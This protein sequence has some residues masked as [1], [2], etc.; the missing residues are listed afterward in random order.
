MAA[1]ALPTMPPGGPDNGVYDKGGRFPAGAINDVHYLSPVTGADKTMIV[2]TPPSYNPSQKYAVVYGFHGAGAGADTI[3]ADWCMGS[4]TVADNLIGEGKITPLIIVAINYGDICWNCSDLYREM[5][6]GVMSYIDSHYSTYA[7]ADHR[8]LVGYSMGGGA[9]LALGTGYLDTFRHLAPFSAAPAGSFPNNGAEAKQ[10]MKTLLLSCGTADWVGLYPQ[11]EARH[12]DLVAMGVPH[13]WWPVAGGNHDAGVWRPAM[14]NFLQLADR[15][16]ISDPPC[17][18][19]AYLQVEA[20]NYDIQSGVISE[21]CGEGGLDIGSIQNGSYLVFKNIDFGSGAVTFDARVTSATSGGN[22]EVRLDSISGTLVGTCTVLGTG[23]WQTWVTRSCSVS[24]ATGKHDLYL[25]FTGSSGYL[26]NINWWKFNTSSLPS[27]PSAPSGLAATAG[28]ERTTLSWTASSTATSYNVKRSTTSGGSYTTV[29]NVA[30]TTYTDRGVIGGTPYYYVVSSLNLG[31]EGANS[32]QASATP[33]VNVPSP[34]LTRDIGAVGLSGGASFANGVFTVTGSGADI[35]DPSDAFRFVHVSATGDCTI[36]T[37]VASL[38]SHINALSKAGVMIRE[39]LAA[40]AANVFIGVTPGNGVIWQY[41]SSTGGGT[42][43][44]NT[45]GIS[46]PY[47]VKLVRSGNT[48]TGSY[49]PNGTTW[50]QLGSMTI[51]MASTT[52][53]GLA[54]TGHN[55]YT[56]CTATFDHVTAPGWAPPAATTPTGLVATAGVERVT[57]NWTASSNANS[58]NV[59][60]ST[61]SGGPYTIIANI[62]TTNYIDT[63]VTGRTTY[64]YVVSAMSNLAG[65]SDNSN[66]A[67]A[68]PTINVPSPWNTGDIGSVGLSGSANFAA[69][70][71][72]TVAGSGGDIWGSNDA[73][74]FVYFQVTGNCTVVARVAGMQNTPPPIDGWAKAGFMIRENLNA[75]SSNAFIAVTPGNGVTFQYRSSAGGGCAN[76]ASSG[77]APYWVRLVRSGDTFTGYCSANG[78]TWTQVGSTTITMAST[79]YIGLA[80]TSHNNSSLCTATFDNVTV[81]GWSSAPLTP[82]AT[83]VSGSQV[84]LTWIALTGATSYNVKR[85]TVSGGPYT[86]IATGVTA[87]NY[88]DNSAPVSTGCYY[89]IS[90][91]VNGSETAN[92]FE[93][94]LD[95]SKL[96]GTIIGTEGSWNNSGNTI[97]KVFDNDLTTFF[98]AP[99]PGNGD[100]VGLDF[101]T[102]SSVIRKINYCPRAGSV[103]RMVGGSFQGANLADFSDAVTLATVGTQPAAGAFTSVSITNTAAFRYVRYLSPNS[104]YGNVAELEFYGYPLVANT[105]PYFTMDPIISANAIELYNYTGQSLAGTAIDPDNDPLTYSKVSGPAWLVVAG[106]GT[107]SGIP[108][109][110]NVGINTFTVKVTDN[111]GLSDTAVMVITVANIYSGVAGMEDL[112]GLAAQW[113]R[114]GCTDTPACNGADLDGD[115]N[116]DLED[117]AVLAFNWTT[118]E[119]LQLYLKLDETS[120]TTAADSSMYNHPGTL[121]NGPVWSAGHTPGSGA[122]SFDGTN[123][124]V[125]ITGYK[126]ITGTSSRTCSAWIKTTTTGALMSWGRSVP[127][128]GDYWYCLVNYS[129]SGNPGALHVSVMGGNVVGTKDLRDGQWHHIAVVFDSD[130]DPDTSDLTLYVDGVAES[131]SYLGLRAINTAAETDVYLGSRLGGA[132]YL[133]SGLMDDVRIYNRALSAAEITALVQ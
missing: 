89:V 86:P 124:S 81:P 122:L 46:V 111:G 110:A 105:A 84:N 3:F 29:A 74:R 121:N 20:E 50:T 44:N 49:S 120:G 73:F 80:V 31:G 67:S 77:S 75:N 8:G 91:M 98:D 23:G 11:N 63:F 42:T 90:A 114:T 125:V 48:F 96:G 94:A 5:S 130:S 26:F 101:G 133:F 71:M 102:A 100:W 40:N 2:Y 54:I 116:V 117:F 76:T 35:G 104:G 10:K 85:S 65:E 57:L 78:T 108:L 129:A 51:T 126:G 97:A 87:I 39:S 36:I 25:K 1:D 92:G 47:W 7:D 68:T 27:L 79:A 113:L 119:T 33:T 69:N 6:E 19:S 72:F 55:A 106:D 131:V 58:Y 118:D 128:G 21:T 52:S 123:D 15:A 30:G 53:V 37:R 64:Y 9:T 61:T 99:D 112:L 56:I 66:Q 43:L 70:G 34:W 18:R 28:I 59:K 60:R 17:P 45:T 4:G 13:A 107:L 83:V 88:T 103:D 93:A 24:G 16:G 14:W 41:R 22:I 115:A 82:K 132:S 32:G 62:T 38:E 95:F 109:N 127:T 12:N